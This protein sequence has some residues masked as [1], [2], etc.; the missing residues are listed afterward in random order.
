M[1]ALP[2]IRT[3][4]H[5]SP[6]LGLHEETRVKPAP[7]KYGVRA[8]MSLAVRGLFTGIPSEIR[9]SQTAGI[10]REMR[11]PL[12]FAPIRHL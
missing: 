2:V 6:T 4:L 9:G 8:V 3:T 5:L 1:V 11:G 7:V 12:A 10:S